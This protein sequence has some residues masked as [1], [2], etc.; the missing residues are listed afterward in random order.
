[1]S[2]SFLGPFQPLP[3]SGPTMAASPVGGAG[4]AAT[5]LPFVMQSQLQGNWCWAATSSSVSAFFDPSSGWSQCNVASASLGSA[6]CSAPLPCDRPFTLDGPL[7]VTGNL[8]GLLAGNDV[9]ASLQAEIDAGRPVCCHISWISGGGHFVALAGYDWSTDDLL[10]DDPL[11]GRQTV[12]YSTFVAAYRGAGSWDYTY[13][14][15]A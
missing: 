12:P 14:T 2:A 1:M 7:T 13:Y 5:T 3:A 8:Q 10:V 11:Y 15:Q 4:F 6:C 9:R